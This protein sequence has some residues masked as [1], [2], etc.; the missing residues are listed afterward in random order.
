MLLHTAYRMS[1]LESFCVLLTGKV[2]RSDLKVFRERLGCDHILGGDED[3]IDFWL[4]LSG[5]C[6]K[7]RHARLHK[8]MWEVI[9]SRP[10]RCLNHGDGDARNIFKVR[11]RL[12]RHRL[13][14]LIDA[15]KAASHCCCSL[16]G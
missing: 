2:W 16:R 11:L 15:R 14:F 3:V 8:R 12:N 1:A 6:D 7:E 13:S 9:N 5:G 10:Y 4:A